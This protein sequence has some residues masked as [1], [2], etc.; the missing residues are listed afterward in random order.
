M[1]TWHVVPDDFPREPLPGVVPGAQPK[2]LAQEKDGQYYT[3]L[4]DDELLTRYE[5]CEDFARQLSAYT[6]RKIR[7]FGWSFADTFAKIERSVNGKVS[8][9]EW[10]FSPAEIAWVM[11]RTRALL[12]AAENRAGGKNA[13]C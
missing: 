12:L 9:G 5:V 2:L 8:A 3:G 11:K 4:A 13:N 1:T 7:Q 6:S 10:D